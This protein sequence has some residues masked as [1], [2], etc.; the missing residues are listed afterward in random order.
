MIAK[1]KYLLQGGLLL[2]ITACA[3]ESSTQLTN[4]NSSDELNVVKEVTEIVNTATP[5]PP[6][7][8]TKIADIIN[9]ATPFPPS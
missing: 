2:L 9:T 3:T 8:Q 1:I 4:I 5:F 7:G 6:S